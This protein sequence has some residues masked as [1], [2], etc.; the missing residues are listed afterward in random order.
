MFWECNCIY[1]FE[2]GTSSVTGIRSKKCIFIPTPFCQGGIISYEMKNPCL[3]SYIYF[4]K[5]PVGELVNFCPIF[6]NSI[7]YDICCLFSGI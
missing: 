6:Q 2:K 3:I 4:S 5:I 1:S 7:F